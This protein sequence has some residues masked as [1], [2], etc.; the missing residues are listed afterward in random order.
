MC[1]GCDGGGLGC[2]WRTCTGRVC[3]AGCS[4][5]GSVSRTAGGNRDGG[6]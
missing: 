5:C 4:N 3:D 1:K 2:S 6:G